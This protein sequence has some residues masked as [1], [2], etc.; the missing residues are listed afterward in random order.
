M[1]LPLSTVN[2]HRNCV[3]RVRVG[4]LTPYC[5]PT[6]QARITLVVR[7][8]MFDNKI[9]VFGHGTNAEWAARRADTQ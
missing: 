7:T 1:V 3:S 2:G 8:E 9:P 6:T 5:Q 4:G